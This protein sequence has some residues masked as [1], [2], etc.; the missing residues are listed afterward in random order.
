[1]LTLLTKVK[2]I[3]IQIRIF[4]E[5]FLIFLSVTEEFSGSIDQLPESIKTLLMKIKLLLISNETFL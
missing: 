5:S 1:M 2:T 4:P 3:F